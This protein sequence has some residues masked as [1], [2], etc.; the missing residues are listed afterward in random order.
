MLAPPHPTYLFTCAYVAVFFHRFPPVSLLSL[1][2][3]TFYK[4][5]FS[6]LRVFH[7]MKIYVITYIDD[8]S[9]LDIESLQLGLVLAVVI[10]L[11]TLLDFTQ[12]QNAIKV[13]VCRTQNSAA[14]VA[15]QYDFFQ[16]IRASRSSRM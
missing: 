11:N 13:C 10:L 2:P 14:S 6:V 16:P 15:K 7:L 12:R 4:P 8:E 3:A 9:N 5:P 1:S